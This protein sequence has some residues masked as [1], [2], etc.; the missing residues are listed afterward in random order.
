MIN[1]FLFFLLWAIPTFIGLSI[2]SVLDQ[3]ISIIGKILNPLLMLYSIIIYYL[4]IIKK[5]RTK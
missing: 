3:N 4:I 5:R 2:K 1:E